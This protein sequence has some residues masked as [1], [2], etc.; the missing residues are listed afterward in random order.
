L[1]KSS[2]P[3]SPGV[4]DPSTGMPR[5]VDD[6]TSSEPLWK[7]TNV[8][9]FV[10]LLPR[11]HSSVEFLEAA[12]RRLATAADAAALGL[13]PLQGNVALEQLM[14]RDYG[15]ESVAA[16]M[17]AG[18]LY[19]TLPIPGGDGLPP[20]MLG[21]ASP[22]TGATDYLTLNARALMI[23]ED[24]RRLRTIGVQ[25]DGG[26]GGVS[27]LYLPGDLDPIC[28]KMARA[29]VR[30]AV[31][32]RAAVG[33][34][35]ASHSVTSAFVMATQR[36]LLPT[37]PVAQLL[38]PLSHPVVAAD[39]TVNLALVLQNALAFTNASAQSIVALAEGFGSTY[40]FAVDGSL[41]ARMAANGLGNP[42]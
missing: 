40:D 1:Y 29:H 26:G 28:W 23:Q 14:A 24:D 12:C 10:G 37:H 4:F 22:L 15:I 31:A 20:N 25:L 33:H 9:D 38:A 27:P 42:R 5:T 41:A 19:A 8:S 32:V 6:G 21:Q 30:H 36:R 11:G 35:I 13:T 34:I 39:A 16:A 17:A 7:P 2:L 18:R 3:A